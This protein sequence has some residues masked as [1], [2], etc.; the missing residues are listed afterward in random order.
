[1]PQPVRLGLAVVASVLTEDTLQLGGA[2]LNLADAEHVTRGFAV[3][4]PPYGAVFGPGTAG[5]AV[6]LRRAIA[7]WL[8]TIP[9]DAHTVG[10][11]LDRETGRVH[12]DVVDVYDSRVT[13]HG[14]AHRRGELAY[15]DLAA[16]EETRLQP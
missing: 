5:R 6:T 1:M 4:R 7:D 2:T 12:V 9:T 11:W 3:G 10:A 15:F 13:A 8:A 14:F 16:G